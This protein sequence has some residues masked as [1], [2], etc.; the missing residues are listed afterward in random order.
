M[1]EYFGFPYEIFTTI[2]CG[3]DAVGVGSEEASA[4]NYDLTAREY[5]L[6]VRNRKAAIYLRMQ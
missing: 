2:R 1:L 3:G 4:Q 5:A 6:H